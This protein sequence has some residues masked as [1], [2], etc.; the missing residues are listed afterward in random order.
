MADLKTFLSL[1]DL[2]AVRAAERPESPAYTLLQG[3]EKAGGLTY[4]E[5]DAR[6][7]ALGRPA[8]RGRRARGAGAA[9]LP[10]GA[11]LRGRLLRLPLR[12]GGGG[13]RLS[14]A[15]APARSPRLRAIAADCR[16]ARW[17]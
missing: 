3:G 11:R 4:A 8:G 15:L 2:L 13:P 14:A 1:V 10:P 5:L 9:A 7:R 6:A 12:R 16:A 17:C